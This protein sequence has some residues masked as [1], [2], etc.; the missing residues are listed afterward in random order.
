MGQLLNIHPVTP[1][2]R[3]LDRAAE[4]LEKDGVVVLPTD[5]CYSLTALPRATNAIQRISRI[6]EFDGSHKLTLT[7]FLFFYRHVQIEVP[8]QP[9]E[10]RSHVPRF[11]V[12]NLPDL[13]IRS[14]LTA[15]GQNEEENRRDELDHGEAAVW[16]TCFRRTRMAPPSSISGNSMSSRWTDTEIPSPSVRRPVLDAVTFEAVG[17]ESVNGSRSPTLSP[18]ETVMQNSTPTRLPLTRTIHEHA[19]Q[20]SQ[21]V[22]FGS[23]SSPGGTLRILSSSTTRPGRL[24]GQNPQSTTRQRVAVSGARLHE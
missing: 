3:F 23:L 8:H 16:R 4:T 19:P 20:T 21:T 9:A 12:A 10:W 7:L 15:A 14:P 24:R 5:T 13:R 22:A 17:Y 2:G 11:R 1:Q 18:K 6:K